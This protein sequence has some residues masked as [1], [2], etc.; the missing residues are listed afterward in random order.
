MLESPLVTLSGFLP[1]IDDGILSFEQECAFGEFV[2]LAA[3]DL[4]IAGQQIPEVV[5]VP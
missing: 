4:S 2:A 1:V 3:V 5:A